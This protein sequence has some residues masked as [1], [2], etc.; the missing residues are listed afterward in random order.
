MWQL[1]ICQKVDRFLVTKSVAR[2]V[3]KPVI[4]WRLRNPIDTF[5]HN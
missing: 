4:D 1:L 2:H 3:D 5:H